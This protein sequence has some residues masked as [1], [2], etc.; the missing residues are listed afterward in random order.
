MRILDQ[1]LNYV[2]TEEVLPLFEKL[3]AEYKVPKLDMVPWEDFPAIVRKVCQDRNL[4]SLRSLQSTQELDTILNILKDHNERVYLRDVVA[5]I[6]SLEA[7][8]DFSLDRHTCASMILEYLP[9]AVF[10]TSTLFQ[11]QTWAKSKS[12]L[13]DNLIHHAP[14]ILRALILAVNEIAGFARQALSELLQEL[15]R[16]SLQDFAELVELIALTVRSPEFALDL[17]LEVLEPETSRLLVGRPTAIQRFTASLSGVALDHVDEAAGSRA[18]LQESIKIDIQ[19]HQDGYCITKSLLR[20]DSSLGAMLK[21]GDHV[22][23]TVT[24]AAVNDPFSRPFSTDALVTKAEPG[25]ATFRCFHNM[26]SY[27]DQCAWNVTQ[28]GSFVTTKACFDAL[29]AF[30]TQQEGC[31]KIYALLLGLSNSDQIKLPNVS[32]PAEKSS[33]LNESQNAAVFA[34]MENLL[35]FIWGPPG[36]GKTH[37]IVIILRQLLSALPKSRIL[38]TAPTH[39]AVDNLLRRFV[40]GED[41][42]KNGIVPLRVS[43]QVSTA[44]M[45]PITQPNH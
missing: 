8:S 11:S 42:R 43:T 2:D 17:L 34:A 10:L 13:E 30:Y 15:K 37:T 28:C 39:N 18:E 3:E 1:W 25:S 29:T 27:A 9:K 45:L 26:P 21:V 4:S 6:L 40:S 32:L 38:V 35:T 16:I 5:H 14:N 12:S 24:N 23:L 22:R 41:V 20:I 44:F 31:C 19:D 7:S 33:T 36:T